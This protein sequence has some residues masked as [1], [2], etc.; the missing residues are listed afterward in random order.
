MDQ[1]KKK[2]EEILLDCYKENQKSLDKAI[3]IISWGAIGFL[4]YKNSYLTENLSIFSLI[5]FFVTV[6][7]HIASLKLGLSG[8]DKSLSEKKLDKTRGIKLIE[9]S[10]TLDEIKLYLFAFSVILMVCSRIFFKN[11]SEDNMS[12]KERFTV[13]P[14]KSMIENQKVNS[15]SESGKL[16]KWVPHPPK[17]VMPESKP[18][19]DPPL[20]NN[21]ENS[22]NPSN[23]SSS[24]E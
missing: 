12:K 16:E 11:Q 13:T 9:T 15:P 19:V 5:G 20:S 22:K 1:E 10:K 14:P 8:C 7:V 4:L 17:S 23:S 3:F 24:S 6:T 18:P 2:Y 21:S